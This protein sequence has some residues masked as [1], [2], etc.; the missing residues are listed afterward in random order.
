MGSLQGVRRFNF[1]CM[2][3]RRCCFG[4]V[5]KTHGIF[6]ELDSD[7]Y[8]AISANVAFISLHAIRRFG[9]PNHCHL[10]LRSRVLDF[11]LQ[12]LDSEKTRDPIP[13]NPGML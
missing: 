1:W 2:S 7:S 11:G 10:F 4:V 9:F 8:C 3:L 13:S 12:I 5:K 6:E